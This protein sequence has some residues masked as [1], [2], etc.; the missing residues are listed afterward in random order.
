VGVGGGGAS[1]HNRIM[2][3]KNSDDD[4]T[5]VL[6]GWVPCGRTDP[7]IDP[8]R[9]LDGWKPAS[10]LDGGKLD[11]S[12]PH[13]DELQLRRRPARPDPESAR[14]PKD[15]DL[16]VPT[17]YSKWDTSDV[18]DIDAV[19]KPADF[20]A[21][22]A[23][24]VPVES[25]WQP[26]AISTNVRKPQHP[27]VLT[28]WKPGA[29]VG[30][31]KSV[32]DSVARVVSTAQ[33]PVVDTYP[34]HVLLALW[35][36]QNMTSPFLDRWPLRVLLSPVQPDEAGAELLN[37]LPPEAEL[38]LAEH[39][40]DWGLV[41]EA[42]LLHEPGLREFQLKE[43]RAFVEAERQA[44]WDRSNKAYKLPASGQPIERI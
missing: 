33:G 38:W 11:P 1:R 19:W 24:E 36:P 17:R 16:N 41:G 28:A 23:E 25:D 37:H 26:G 6:D 2:S 13:V 5:R 22:A 9:V 10:A 7:G 12:L 18:T 27:R 29:W 31:V 43:L 20:V 39:D 35:A 4:L 40:I 21:R 14:L 15:L 34:P 3:S 32:F 44:T 42:V 30:A 8:T